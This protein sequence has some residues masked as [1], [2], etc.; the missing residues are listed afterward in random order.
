MNGHAGLVPDVACGIVA[1]AVVHPIKMWR[2]ACGVEDM[3]KSGDG[4]GEA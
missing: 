1:P 2:W 3:E 4:D